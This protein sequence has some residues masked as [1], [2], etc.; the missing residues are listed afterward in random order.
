MHSGAGDRK[1]L[2]A[3]Q[4]FGMGAISRKKLLTDL[5]EGNIEQNEAEILE[6]KK[7]M[8]EVEAGVQQQLM[9][10]QEAAKAGG[11]PDGQMLAQMVQ[12]ASDQGG[13]PPNPSVGDTP[14]LTRGQRNGEL[15]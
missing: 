9:Q 12:S 10:Q 1:K 8:L 7:A 6:E 15:V 14:R 2:M 13:G 4:L 3:T 11:S 5:D